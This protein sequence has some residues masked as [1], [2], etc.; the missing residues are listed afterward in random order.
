MTDS[1]LAT[2]GG[3]C[4]WCT[5]AIYAEVLGVKSVTSGYAGGKTENP[6]YKDICS[7]T[8]GHA[9]VIQVEF[10]SDQI[11]Y[12]ELLTIFFA[13]HDPTTLNQQ[14]ADMGTQYRSIIFT[15]DDQQNDVAQQLM[16]ELDASD[17]FASPIVTLIEPLPTFY[18][19]EEYHQDYYQQNGGQPYCNAVIK[20]KLDKFRTRFADK[21]AK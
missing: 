19:A 6:T 4:F 12:R 14:G 3:G 7:G 21:R 16:S 17:E 13:T 2:F 8:T 5:E 9:E 10:D 15:H 18:P 20:P 1:S 11:T